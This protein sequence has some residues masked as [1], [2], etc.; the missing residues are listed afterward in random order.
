[1][2]EK[3]DAVLRRWENAIRDAGGGEHPKPYTQNIKLNI[4]SPKP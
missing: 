4:L 1:M 3:Y 2:R